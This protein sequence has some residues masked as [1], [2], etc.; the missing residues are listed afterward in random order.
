MNS[1][2]YAQ[3]ARDEQAKA[4][5]LL[6]GRRIEKVVVVTYCD[7]TERIVL[8]LDDGAQVQVSYWVEYADDAGLEFG[9]EDVSP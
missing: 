6:A 2:D 8:T 9:D 3:Y 1:D 7:R 5:R 4:D